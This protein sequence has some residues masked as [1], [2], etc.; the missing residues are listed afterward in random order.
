[1]LLSVVRCTEDALKAK[2]IG[3]SEAV[4][5]LAH[6]SASDA[7]L[8]ARN[9]LSQFKDLGILDVSPDEDH[10]EDGSRLSD[11]EFR[12]WVAMARLEA[13]SLVEL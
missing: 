7:T 8:L 4:L 6:S 5:A 11:A 3:A 12:L 9:L 10:Y 1:M 2:V 13:M